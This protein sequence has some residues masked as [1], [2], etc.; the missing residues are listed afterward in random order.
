ML[1]ICFILRK[2]PLIISQRFTETYFS[3]ENRKLITRLEQLQKDLG[4]ILKE[5][6]ISEKE[7]EKII[8][9][10]PR[11]HTEYRTSITNRMAQFLLE[12]RQKAMGY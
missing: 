2:W 1:T 8:N 9:E 5:L 11:Q 12:K 4:F 10:P 6:L 3:S 7:F